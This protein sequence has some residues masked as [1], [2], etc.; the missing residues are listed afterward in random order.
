MK[1]RKWRHVIRSVSLFLLSR[2]KTRELILSAGCGR[3]GSAS[4]TLRADAVDDAV[5]KS[6]CASGNCK[7]SSDTVAKC[8]GCRRSR[9][10][11]KS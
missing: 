3:L 8:C 6:I 4:G 10:G 7:L 5:D 11:G 1:G 9:W 2:L